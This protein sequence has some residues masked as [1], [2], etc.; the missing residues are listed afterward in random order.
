MKEKLMKVL[1][2]IHATSELIVDYQRPRGFRDYPI[3]IMALAITSLSRWGLEQ[4]E[5]EE[6][7]EPPK[8]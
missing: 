1:T 3:T 6:G 4:I 5:K 8:E 2:M 7:P